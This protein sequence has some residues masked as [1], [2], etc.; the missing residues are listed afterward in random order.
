MPIGERFA[1]FLKHPPVA[2]GQLGDDDAMDAGSAH[3]LHSNLSNA[4]A[5]NTRLIG[6]QIGPGPVG[7][8]GSLLGQ[9][10]GIVDAFN[11]DSS[12][13]IAAIPWVQPDQCICL[14]PWPLAMTSVGADGYRPRSVR[15]A[16]EC[17]KSS[18]SGTSLDV[19]AVLTSAPGTPLVAERLAVAQSIHLTALHAG[20][21]VVDLVLD[22]TPTRPRET[23]R[24]REAS[25]SDGSVVVAPAWLW[26]GWLAFN[27]DYQDTVDAISAWE[28]PTP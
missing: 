17:S 3:I 27:L 6:H 12:D 2:S 21:H 20:D 16:V 28:I 25:T 11:P 23:W 15:V 26:V 24:S 1:G 18:T 19:F 13:P 10:E 4:S 8:D 7:Y 22:P 14:G 9:W 5:Q